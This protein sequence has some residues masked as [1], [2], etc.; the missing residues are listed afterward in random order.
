MIFEIAKQFAVYPMSQIVKVD[1]TIVGIEAG[2]NAGCWT[3][4]ITK[5]GNEVGLSEA[6]ANSLPPEEL[7]QQVAQADA[8]FRAGGAHFTVESVADIPDLVGLINSRLAA[9]ELPD[10]CSA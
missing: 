2:R 8:K 9:G 5:S 4:G 10:A 1:D 7:A 6:E 3:V